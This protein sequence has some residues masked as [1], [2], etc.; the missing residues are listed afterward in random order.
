MHISGEK[1]SKAEVISNT[2]EFPEFDLEEDARAIINEKN[3]WLGYIAVWN[4]NTPFVQN[5]II[6][7]IDPDYIGTEIEMLLNKWAEKKLF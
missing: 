2:L 6:Q 5:H 3:E 1:L 4:N 7:K